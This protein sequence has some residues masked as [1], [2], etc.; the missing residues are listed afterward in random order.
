MSKLVQFPRRDVI[1]PLN[2]LKESFSSPSSQKSPN[3]PGIGLEKW[4]LFISKWLRCMHLARSAGNYPPV[5]LFHDKSNRLSSNIWPISLGMLLFK[6]FLPSRRQLKPMESTNWDG[7]SHE[8]TIICQVQCFEK[9][10]TTKR[11]YASIQFVVLE[12]DISRVFQMNRSLGRSPSRELLY[13]TIICK[14]SRIPKDCGIV[15]EL[16]ARSLFFYFFSNTLLNS[17]S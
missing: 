15:R 17:L 4:L 16:I 6:P 12:I 11:N 7:I 14:P 10:W 3:H 5:S 2:S 13:R 1:V 8:K 9:T